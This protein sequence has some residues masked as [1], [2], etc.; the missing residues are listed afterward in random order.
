MY[1]WGPIYALQELC[2]NALRYIKRIQFLIQMDPKK[3]MFICNLYRMMQCASQRGQLRQKYF[4]TH[5]IPSTKIFFM[6]K[7]AAQW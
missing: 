4:G 1:L 3:K 7:A 2:I 5:E 6:D